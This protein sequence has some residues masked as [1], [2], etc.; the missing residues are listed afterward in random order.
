MTQQNVSVPVGSSATLLN[1][2]LPVNAVVYNSD[3]KSTVWISSNPS[4]S[5]GNGI[6]VPA[7]GSVQWSGGAIYACVDAGVTSPV[8]L[9]LTTD[10]TN[11]SNPVSIAS[12]VAA[13]LLKQGIPTVLT[14]TLISGI[15]NNALFDVS[16][17]S[18]IAGVLNVPGP[19]NINL[20]FWDGT[21]TIPLYEKQFTFV[22]AVTNFQF[23]SGVYGPQ[24]TI[25]SGGGGGGAS[26]ISVFGS[27]RSLPDRCYSSG[28]Y[29]ASLNTTYPGGSTA[30]GSA[31]FTNGGLSSLNIRCTSGPSTTGFLFGFQ[32]W[33][34]SQS[35][36]G[37]LQTMWVCTSSELVA[38]KSGNYNYETRFVLPAGYLQPMVLAFGSGFTGTITVTGTLP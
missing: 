3:T 16:G 34:S 2:N 31:L 33:D 37:V 20:I 6:P 22:K 12:A 13:Q 26:S 17:Y 28:P 21:G 5:P 38:D 24:C 18:S 23:S 7:L 4:C 8:S 10:A 11:Y 19:C 36:P 27:N 9:Y 32:Y 14:G 15:T 1:S 25:G 29:Y 30:L 35:V